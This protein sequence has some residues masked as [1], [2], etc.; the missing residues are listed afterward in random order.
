MVTCRLLV[1]GLVMASTESIETQ[2]SDRMTIFS[3]FT[4]GEIL[5]YE[6]SDGSAQV[7]VRLTRK[8]YGSP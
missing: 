4:S 6:A 8:R 5:I 1:I 2:P 3:E 7:D